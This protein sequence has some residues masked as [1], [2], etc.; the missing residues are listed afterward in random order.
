MIRK[1]VFGVLWLALGQLSWGQTAG[2][3]VN[4]S[5]MVAPPAIAPNVDA[6]NF[7][8]HN[9]F[10][11]NFTNIEPPWYTFDLSLGYNTGDSPSIEYLRG[12]T[13]QLV[14]QNLLNKHSPFEYGP[15]TSTRNPAAYDILKPNQG[16]MIGITLL[17][18]W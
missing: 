14:V 15:G 4:D 11:I 10:V 1:L 13:I 2:L 6:T 17:K 9:V 18:N 5:I 7:V 12:M 16:R 8:N 3:Y